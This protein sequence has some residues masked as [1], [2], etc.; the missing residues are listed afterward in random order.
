VAKPSLEY[1]AFIRTTPDRLWE[2][3]T[4]PE[5]TKQYFYGLKVVSD[6]KPGSS[7]KHL[8]P[9]GTAQIE[10]KVTEIEPKRKL[11]HTFATAGVSDAPSRVAW[12]IQPMGAVTLLTL[13]HDDFD[14]ETQ[15]YTSV[16]RGWNPVVSGLKTLLETGRPLEIPAPQPAASA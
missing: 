12:E 6:W 9:D 7:L 13:T 5:Q 15:T 1:Q 4:N 16:A 14:G 10:G 11:V 3:I 8:L 2:A